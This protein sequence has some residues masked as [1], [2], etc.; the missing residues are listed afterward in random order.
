M[1]SHQD[2]AGSNAAIDARRRATGD[3]VYSPDI[4]AGQRRLENSIAGR[5]AGSEDRNSKGLSRMFLQR[6]DG[7]VIQQHDDGDAQINERKEKERSED[8][9]AEAGKSHSPEC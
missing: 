9:R 7:I 6:R 8:N 4:G 5:P 1:Q 2:L 3:H